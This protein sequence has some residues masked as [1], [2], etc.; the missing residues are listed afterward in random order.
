M[1]YIHI[2]TIKSKFLLKNNFMVH[3]CKLHFHQ[4]EE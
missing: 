2:L 1:V 3:M 4:N